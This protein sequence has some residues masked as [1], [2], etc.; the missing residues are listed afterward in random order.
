MWPCTPWPVRRREPPSQAPS[1]HGYSTVTGTCSWQPIPGL[2]PQTSTVHRSSHFPPVPIHRPSQRHVR[3]N[4]TLR[5]R[6]SFCSL[7]E[8]PSRRSNSLNTWRVAG[9]ALRGRGR[10]VRDAIA[11]WHPVYESH[12]TANRA[13][14]NKDASWVSG[15]ILDEEKRHSRRALA[16]RRAALLPNR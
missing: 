2:T 7:R 10:Q 8:R 3:R 13:A 15:M 1:G 4:H 11:V 9:F 5:A 12:T 16:H 14:L 6:H